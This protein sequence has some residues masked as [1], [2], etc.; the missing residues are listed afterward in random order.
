MHTVP[1]PLSVAGTVTGP[2]VGTMRGDGP[3]PLGVRT[4]MGEARATIYP[5]TPAATEE[6]T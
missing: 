6:E 3:C 5:V 2:G 1:T 4:L